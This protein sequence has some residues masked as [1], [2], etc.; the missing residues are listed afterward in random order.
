MS[1]GRGIDGINR[2]KAL[3]EMLCRSVLRFGGVVRGVDGVGCFFCSL[4][5]R[6]DEVSYIYRSTCVD[7]FG[8]MSTIRAACG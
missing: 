3:D 6:N 1:V 8:L 4:T 7:M 5:S 2:S